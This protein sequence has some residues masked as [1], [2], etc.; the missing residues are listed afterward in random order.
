V[1]AFAEAVGLVRVG[2][3]AGLVERYAADDLVA[4]LDEARQAAKEP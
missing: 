2:Q 4:M 3:K 1:Q